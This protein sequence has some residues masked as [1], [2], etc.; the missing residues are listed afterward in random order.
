[1]TAFTAI[2]LGLAIGF[3]VRERRKAY[4][5]WLPIWGF[6]LLGQTVLLARTDD[7]VDGVYPFIQA[8]IFLAGVA[9]AWLAGRLRDQGAPAGT[10]SSPPAS[11]EVSSSASKRIRLGGTPRTVLWLIASAAGLMLATAGSASAQPP[12]T[13]TEVS[14]FS[15]SFSD[16]T[17]FCQDEL[18]AVTLNGHALVH[19]TFFEETGALHFHAVM[20]GKSVSVPLDGTG[21]SYTAN[22]RNS[23]SE[24]IRAVKHGDVLVETDTD[25]FTVV[26][27]GSDGSRAFVTFHAHFTVNAIGNTTVRLERDKLVCS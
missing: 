17:F 4:L 9:C 19:F 20:H 13:G 8:A 15:E 1:M 14:T 27:H 22:F 2:V 12:L 10:A 5:V 25:F 24:N 26:A 7:R 18:Y 6:V 3:L 21:P 16:E 23:D 11:R